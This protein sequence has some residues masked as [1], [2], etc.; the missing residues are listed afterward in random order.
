MSIHHLSVGSLAAAVL[1]AGCADSPVAPP[2][3]TLT[4][5]VATTGDDP[6][7]DGYLIRVDES[8]AERTTAS[9][10]IVFADLEPGR[11]RIALAEVDS[12]CLADPEQG[13]SVDLAA[14][15]SVRVDF[16][17]HCPRTGIALGVDV[18]GDDRDVAFTAT[19]NGRAYPV[20]TGLFSLNRLAPGAYE[21]SLSDI[22]ENCHAPRTSE[23]AVV[24]RGE[25]VP[26]RFA[27]ACRDTT[28]GV[29]EVTT[30][31]TN[32]DLDP[33]GYSISIDQR[34][35]AHIGPG[36]VV[37]IDR[38]PKGD[39]VIRLGDL[40]A[41]C[42]VEGPNPRTLRVVLADTVRTAFQVTCTRL[43]ALA[44]TRDNRIALLS[45]DGSRLKLA[46]VGTAPAWSPDGTRLAFDCGP[47]CIS[48][49]DGRAHTTIGLHEGDDVS[50]TDDGE[51]AWRS[52]SEIAVTNVTCY[53][54]YSKYDYCYYRHLALISTR[55]GGSR[56]EIPLPGVYWAG[57]LAWSVDGRRLAFTCEVEPLNLDVCAV[58]ADGQDF[59]RLTDDPGVDRS[60]DWAP[61][62]SRI[63]FATSRFQPS[64]AFEIALMEPDGQR[65]TRVGLG[66]TGTD[67]AWS[68]DGASIA[69]SAWA[70]TP[71][72]QGCPGECG[73]FLMAPDGAQLRRLSTGNDRAAAWR[74]P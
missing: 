59:R 58:D 52:D 13:L 61:D 44:A 21:V 19:V 23:T 10:A 53:T 63:V 42:R 48:T 6:D 25:V 1:L 2:P 74:R 33:S 22:A 4:V 39:R 27:V 30:V 43:W 18:T 68:P 38:V 34:V 72:G 29:V 73:L 5:G 14:G 66:T 35:A 69:F 26:I 17:V 67:P 41:N 32:I 9:G 71:S 7:L 28:N 56:T 55:P 47:I 40:T 15:G 65:V 64:G 46:D 57:E 8:R 24:P 50:L 45:A 11:H 37:T 20:A 49:L 51:P 16:R 54:Y 62:G 3:P 60:P 12:H 31:T 70:G 36:A